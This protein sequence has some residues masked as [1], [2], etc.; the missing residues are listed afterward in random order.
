MLRVGGC[1]CVGAFKTQSGDA[2]GPWGRSVYS[3][4]SSPGSSGHVQ[5]VPEQ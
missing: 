5:V 3:S 4:V 2:L 1:I